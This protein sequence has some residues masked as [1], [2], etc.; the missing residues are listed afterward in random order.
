MDGAVR[1]SAASSPSL[2]DVLL[3]FPSS[4]SQ[5]SELQ[6]FIYGFILVL[7]PTATIL[8]NGLVIVSV[9][10]F[11][12]LHSAINFLILGLA[13]A[14]LGVALFVMP[15]AVYVYVQGGRWLLG[16]L[17]CNLYLSSDV[18]C[19]TASIILLALI[20]FDRYQAISHPI[21]Y[22]RQ[23]QNI[24]R[25]VRLFVGVWVYSLLVASPIVL[26][27]ND[28]PPEES[29]SGAFE[30]FECRFYNP[31]FSMLSSFVSFLLPCCVVIFVYLRIIRAL[32]KRERAAKARKCAAANSAA[33]C[34]QQQKTA[35]A[36]E[37]QQLTSENQMESEEAGEIVAGPAI[38][39]MMIA[40][41]S[42]NRKMC[43]YERHRRALEEAALA[44][45][46][47]MSSSESLSE[48]I[49]ILTN[50][51]FSEV[52]TSNSKGSASLGPS[53]GCP[54][55]TLFNGF[56]ASFS[57]VI[58][59]R[60]K[61]MADEIV[62]S[63]FVPRK[64]SAC[65]FGTFSALREM[66]RQNTAPI[67]IRVTTVRDDSIKRPETE[68]VRRSQLLA[69][70]S[71]AWAV[72]TT[73]QNSAEVPRKKSN[74]QPLK[75]QRNCQRHAP[76]SRGTLSFPLVKRIAL[77]RE[78]RVNHYL[79]NDGE[80]MTDLIVPDNE[81]G[82]KGTKE[83]QNEQQQR[84]RN[85]TEVPKTPNGT[86]FGSASFRGPSLNISSVP[87]FRRGISSIELARATAED[88]E[89]NDEEEAPE[90][91]STRATDE[92]GVKESEISNGNAMNIV[93][94]TS[95]VTK[96]AEQG[97]TQ[98]KTPLTATISLGTEKT[99]RSGTVMA[100]EQSSKRDRHAS[101]R[102]KV[103]KSQ[104]KE[105]RATK[106]LGIVVGTFLCCWVPFFSLNIANALCIEMGADW[107]QIG[108][109][110]FFY[111]TWL[112]YMNSFMNPLIYTIFNAEF[113]RAFKSL[114]LGR[115]GN[116]FARRI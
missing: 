113:R 111:S 116:V 19:S 53:G 48:D 6:L 101:L 1:S 33:Q 107:C 109:G 71:V 89:N 18:A 70:E 105:K 80:D 4:P 74:A 14:D 78:I 5:P 29:A 50:D 95:T 67:K 7:I 30:P 86:L 24:A 106:T 83:R 27:F 51:F 99:A 88:E 108:F 39:M 59:M 76:A 37:K 38:N 93:V 62:P 65:D 104:R 10:R 17:M 46:D 58:D 68:S 63:I 20:S 40:L 28:P 91:T 32:R 69:P 103:H 52:P 54:S 110:P 61:S 112:G 66:S 98:R 36:S 31:W 92:S 115:R 84:L 42:L 34:Q 2:S 100:S 72:P 44:E 22:S 79:L 13:I 60:K 87:P 8:G 75:H 15:Y 114:L 55:A 16:P 82:Q 49:R 47:G 102:R 85:G 3:N 81:D 26:G 21:Q 11:K 56:R 77:G 57:G 43:R 96:S 64:R 23:A 41:P 90:T 45:D 12:A 25:V 73:R 9:L 35:N 97:P 94:S